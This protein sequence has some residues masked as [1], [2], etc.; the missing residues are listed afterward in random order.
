MLTN[1][2]KREVELGSIRHKI[3]SILVDCND[4]PKGSVSMAQITI[5]LREQFVQEYLLHARPE[6]AIEEAP[7]HDPWIKVEDLL[8]DYQV[9]VLG[10]C[11]KSAGVT[12][13]STIVIRKCTDETGEVWK[14][15]DG[16]YV[17]VIA[18]MPRPTYSDGV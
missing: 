7:A 18:W 8:P 6:V 1:D 12:W 10:A 11:F 2:E 14:A 13:E 9:P 16:S 15:T 4:G 3:R 17:H 5:D